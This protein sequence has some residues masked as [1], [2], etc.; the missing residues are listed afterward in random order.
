MDYKAIKSALVIWYSEKLTEQENL[1]LN[2]E[3]TVI[4][5]TPKID[6]FLAF[7]D[8]EIDFMNKVYDNKITQFSEFVNFLT[9][10]LLLRG[11]FRG[12][13]N[14]FIK[15]I[16]SMEM[17]QFIKFLVD[18][19]NTGL[20]SRSNIPVMIS[21]DFLYELPNETDVF[22]MI[23]SCEECQMPEDECYFAW[24]YRKDEKYSIPLWIHN[25][26]NMWTTYFDNR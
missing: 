18:K 16:K 21:R 10:G 6:Y 11:E 3:N 1:I 19:K 17:M 12:R 20:S 15:V 26:G 25:N 23:A 4:Y 7:Q 14:K 13:D 9:G 24:L 8:S 5:G 22:T 2:I